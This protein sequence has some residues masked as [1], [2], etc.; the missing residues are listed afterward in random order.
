MLGNKKIE[1]M[2]FPS[3]LNMGISAV[4]FKPDEIDDVRWGGYAIL[5][6]Y[7]NDSIF[8]TGKYCYDYAQK[9]GCDERILR[10]IGDTWGD[11]TEEKNSS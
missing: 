4:T 3:R 9:V 5:E 6:N 8:M 2:H 11:F 10:L 1:M 7:L